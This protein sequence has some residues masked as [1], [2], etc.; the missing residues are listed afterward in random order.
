MSSLYCG[1]AL[2]EV[3]S[4]GNVLLPDFLAEALTP[5][6]SQSE[7]L[8]ST[9][10]TDQCLVGYA[11][12]HLDALLART[13]RWREADEAAGR[14]AEGHHRRAR[15]FFGMVERAPRDADHLRLPAALRCIGRIGD[16]ALFVG[17]G[18][19]F[20][21]WN[22]ELA[23]A[24]GDA[25]LR[26]LTQWRLAAYRPRHRRAGTRRPRPSRKGGR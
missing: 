16:I 6:N 15:H 20:E 14:D 8:I 19:R 2:C 7:L 25:E 18:D 24:A 3:D 13:E 10:E 22:P 26:A 11:R 5:D 4:D 9:H 12:D 17:A 21:I 1:F 23:L